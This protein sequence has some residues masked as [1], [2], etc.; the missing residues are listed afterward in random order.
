MQRKKNL[1]ALAFLIIATAF[2]THAKAST[3]YSLKFTFSGEESSNDD[4]KK[5]ILGCLP[6][7]TW[8]DEFPGKP[9][10]KWKITVPAVNKIEWNTIQVKDRLMSTGCDKA[11]PKAVSKV[12]VNK[13]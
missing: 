6:N 13:V 9:T 4:M 8:I 11:R 10:E 1:A 5:Y 3:K 12:S 2:A 7:K